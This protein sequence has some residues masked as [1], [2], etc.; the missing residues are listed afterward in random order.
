[1]RCRDKRRHD[2]THHWPELAWRPWTP[3]YHARRASMTSP[4]KGHGPASFF[5]LSSLSLHSGRAWGEFLFSLFSSSHPL[6]AFDQVCIC[7]LGLNPLVHKVWLPHLCFFVFSWCLYTALVY[8]AV[9]NTYFH[10]VEWKLLWLIT[11]NI[12]WF[13][14]YLLNFYDFCDWFWLPMH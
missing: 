6:F 12:L 2:G 13:M 1:M 10:L 14:L 4:Y 7:I 3:P 9:C 5:S 8:T 11:F